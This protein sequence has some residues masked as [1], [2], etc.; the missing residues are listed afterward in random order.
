ML[1]VVSGIKTTKINIFVYG[2]LLFI[3]SL[4]PAYFG[5]FGIIYFISSFII[6][7]YYVYLC[8]QLLTNENKLNFTKL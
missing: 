6:G 1:P 8:F 4:M 5:Y 7:L 2:I 3:I